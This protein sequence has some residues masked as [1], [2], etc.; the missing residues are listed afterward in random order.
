M[1]QCTRSNSAT[2]SNGTQTGYSCDGNGTCKAGNVTSCAPYVC[3]SPGNACLTSCGSDAECVVSSFCGPAS[4][5]LADRQPGLPCDRNGQ[6]QSGHCVDGICCDSACAGSC[7][8]C[9]VADEFGERLAAEGEI[10][11]G[12]MHSW[13]RMLDLLERVGQPD[14]LGFQAD[15]AHTL[16]YTLGY[17]APEDGLLPP[18]WNWSSRQPLDEALRKLTQAL[19]PWTIDFHVAQNDAT[20][21]GSGTHDKTGHHC[22]P[23]DPNGKLDVARHAGYWL[24]DE[25]GRLTRQFQ[26]VCWDGCMFPN[27]VMMQP[28]TWNRILET[29]LAVRAAHGWQ[30]EPQE[31]PK[32]LP[33]I[34]ARKRKP[35]AP[36]R[37][38]SKKAKAT[39][40]KVKRRAKSKPAKR[41][42][43]R[44]LRRPA[45]R[46]A[47]R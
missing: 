43:S 26:H 18:A 38:P 39:R 15:M 47:R 33:V 29:M 30:E 11:W 21:K 41:S 1:K 27:A 24:R 13:K 5:C 10:C 40:P 32:P 16:L 17:N 45:K 28:Q 3:D 44:A 22:L 12:G 34:R 19:R 23:D 31:Q 4:T 46:R 25:A 42:K 7:E 20:V 36:A 2:C 9:D 14:T 37:K 35:K 6:C 8:A